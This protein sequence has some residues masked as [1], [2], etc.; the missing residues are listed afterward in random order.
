MLTD[1]AHRVL[2]VLAHLHELEVQAVKGEQAAADGP[3][4]LGQFGA[5]RFGEQ[6]GDLRLR[7]RPHSCDDQDSFH[8][9]FSL[10]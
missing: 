6:P 3:A 2:R 4:E 9:G 10:A 7:G 5:V 1:L 8:S